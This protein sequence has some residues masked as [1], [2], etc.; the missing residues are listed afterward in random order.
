VLFGIGFAVQ[1]EPGRTAA[2]GAQHQYHGQN[3]D[4]QFFAATAC[5][6]FNFLIGFHFWVRFQSSPSCCGVFHAAIMSLSVA[7]RQT[8]ALKRG[9]FPVLLDISLV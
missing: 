1:E 9:A 3:D 5:G 4:D 2:G 6:C 8:E 7:P